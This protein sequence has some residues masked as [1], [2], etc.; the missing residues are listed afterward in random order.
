MTE[1]KDLEESYLLSREQGFG[2]EAKRRIMIGAHVLSSGYY[3]AYYKKAQTVR[4]KIIEEFEDAFSKFDF[5]LGPTCPGVSLLK[6]AKNQENL[7][8]CI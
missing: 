5:L 7:C 1:A 2:A 6:L 8:R 4:T 3:D